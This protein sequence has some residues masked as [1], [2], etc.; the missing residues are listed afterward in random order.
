MAIAD[1]HADQ[2]REGKQDPQISGAKYA[3]RTAP[4]RIARSSRT[5]L[6]RRVA[7]ARRAGS[8]PARMPPQTDATQRPVHQRRRRQSPDLLFIWQAV[9]AVVET[10]N[11]I[12]LS[13]PART[14]RSSILSHVWSFSGWQS[15]FP[16]PSLDARKSQTW[17]R[18]YR[19]VRAM[20]MQ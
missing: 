10:R 16:N 19:P 3:S 7:I 15:R 5:K 2:A 6:L 18:F 17:D 13:A 14:T 9:N 1:G 12:K 20:R 4:G 8:F 11:G